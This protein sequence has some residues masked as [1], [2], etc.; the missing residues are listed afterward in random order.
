MRALLVLMLLLPSLVLAAPPVD[1]FVQGPERV[2]QTQSL[3]GTVIGVHPG[4][5]TRCYV[6]RADRPGVAAAEGLG[7]NGRFF[8]CGPKLSLS[9]G[10]AWKGTAVQTDTRLARMGPR[11]RV[12]PLFEVR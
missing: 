10:Q 2:G 9:M 8:L 4:L 11:W 3:A 5:E 7:G 1:R 6:V 12:L